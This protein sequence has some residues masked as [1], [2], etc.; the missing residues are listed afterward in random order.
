MYYKILIFRFLTSIIVSSSC[1]KRNIDIS[2]ALSNLGLKLEQQPSIAEVHRDERKCIMGPNGDK[3]GLVLQ[4]IFVSFYTT[5]VAIKLLSE[6][7]GITK[8]SYKNMIEKDMIEEFKQT[9]HENT[10]IRFWAQKEDN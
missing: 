10:I 6:E 2:V 1:L 8:E 4:D 7:L 5:E 3:I 9:S